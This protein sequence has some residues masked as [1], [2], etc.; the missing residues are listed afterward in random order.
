MF[1]SIIGHKSVTYK[2]EIHP[3]TSPFLKRNMKNY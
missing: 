2:T 3:P 1:N